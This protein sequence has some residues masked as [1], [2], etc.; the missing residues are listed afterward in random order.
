MCK[1]NLYIYFHAVAD[2]YK[3][4]CIRVRYGGSGKIVYP[5][6]RAH[7]KPCL[8]RCMMYGHWEAKGCYH[9]KRTG[10]CYLEVVEIEKGDGDDEFT[11]WKFDNMKV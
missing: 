1:I 9:H 3:G 8:R 7:E 11:C 2:T 5:I 10:V 4:R 6:A